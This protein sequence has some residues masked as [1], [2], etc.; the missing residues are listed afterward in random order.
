MKVTKLA[1][2]LGFPEGPFPLGDGRLI[3]VETY[4]SQV[5]VWS[6][7]GKV[8]QFAY[9]GGG[10]NAAIMGSDGCCY[11]TQ[12]G[13]VIGPWRAADKRPPSLQRVTPEGKVEVIATE[14]DGL[15]LRAP[16]D[17]VFGPDGRLYF[18]DPGGAFD[19]VNRP[20]P[21]R[22]FALNP[23]GTGE[24]IL[25][26]EPT[27]PNGIVIEANGDLAW[28]ETYTN[29]LYR[30]SRDGTVRKL[31]DLPSK[32]LPDG[33]KVAKDGNFYIAGLISE[34]VII[35]SADGS[36][37]GFIKVGKTPTNCV[38]DGNMLY[39][40]DGGHLG[41]T[42]EAPMVGMLWA[43]EL[44]GVE[45]QPPFPGGIARGISAG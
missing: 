30:R 3:F 11:V 24:L 42:T 28:V 44:D 2:G 39:V 12:N 18:T 37:A 45:G 5:S 8:S 14:V 1:D 10:P 29:R 34:G 40:T 36:E 43:V 26:L 33:F 20:D 16:N 9:V 23:D 15:T 22:I 4:R 38:F 32:G 27:Y 13:G 25:E 6:P 41:M 19:P 31:C 21:G 35:I 17:L 7:D